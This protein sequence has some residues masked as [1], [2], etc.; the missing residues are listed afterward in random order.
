MSRR[1]RA[2]AAFANVVLPGDVNEKGQPIK[3]ASEASGGAVYLYVGVPDGDEHLRLED[4]YQAREALGLPRR[5]VWVG[6][7]GI[8][9]TSD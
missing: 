4:F 1:D 9:S 5:K 3:G 8:W 2:L 7:D 6:V